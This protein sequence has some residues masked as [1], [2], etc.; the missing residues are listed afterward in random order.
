MH[1]LLQTLVYGLATG[2]VIAPAA[3]GLTL[4]FGVTGFINFAYG[5]ILTVAAYATFELAGAGVPLAAAGALAVCGCGIF[6][7]VVARLF[8]EPL[9][10]RGALP[11]LLTSVGVAFVI[12]NI[13]GI[14]AG[15]NPRAF[16]VPLYSPWHL[17]GGILI[18]KL[19]A[20]IFAV[21]CVAM[22]AVHLMLRHTL[23]G[24]TMRAVASNDS[25]ARLS[26]IDTRRVVGSTWFVSGLIAGLGGVLL[27]ASQGSITPTMGFQF[28]LVIFA[29]TMLGGIG[30][31]YGAMIGS[32]IIGL[33]VELGATY[34]SADYS[35]AIAFGALVVALL[36]R[37]QGLFGRRSLV[38]GDIA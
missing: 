36:L 38:T 31:P 32:V 5:E 24:R 13:V 10:G 29:A 1:L 4:S 28:L 6:T 27:G 14:A 37:P 12:Q 26:G 23:L 30:K 8:F 34:V 20:F 17:G 35:Y 33:G 9:R 3:V 22:L 7:W 21:A 25:L 15:G 11:L 2:A 16:P 19:Q 18:P